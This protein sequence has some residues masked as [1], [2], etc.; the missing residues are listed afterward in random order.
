MKRLFGELNM[1]WLAVILFA[2]I[3]GIYTGGILLVDFLKDTSFQDIGISFEWWVI[4]AVIIVVNCRK[5]WEAML[6]C[7]V[8]FLLSQPLVYAVQ[9][10]FGD[11]SPDKALYYY[12]AIW[13][14]MTLLTLPGGF[15]A[16][17]CKKQNL[18]G[19]VILG[20][21]NTI[22]ALLGVSYFAQAV[23]N[24]P[25]HLL[26]AAVCLG[27]IFLM[28][29]QIQKKRP[30]RFLSVLIPLVLTVT[31]LILARLSGRTIL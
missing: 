10:L 24:F 12:R 21:G 13:F 31:L 5:N 6:K 18:L 26:S 29:F 28:T 4:F 30:Y 14:P 20:L 7:F 16:Y 25:H 23:S 8:F 2:A 11:L 27:S 1:S 15:I 19:A 9:V 22:Q 17:Y 3:A